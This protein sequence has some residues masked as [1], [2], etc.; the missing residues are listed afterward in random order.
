MDRES[1]RNRRRA[2]KRAGGERPRWH[3]VP[4][5]DSIWKMIDERAKKQ[6]VSTASQV[7][8]ILEASL[9]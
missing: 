1:G 7:A 3:S 6:G 9:G 5:P 8:R 4:V 2:R